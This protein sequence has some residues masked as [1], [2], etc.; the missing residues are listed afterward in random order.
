MY[1]VVGKIGE[2]GMQIL[3]TA[4]SVCA[5]LDPLACPK[6]IKHPRFD[7]LQLFGDDPNPETRQ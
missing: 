1:S 7:S 6:S 2:K 3:H 5:P 4:A